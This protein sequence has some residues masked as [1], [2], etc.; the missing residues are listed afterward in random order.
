MFHYFIFYLGFCLLPHDHHAA[1]SSLS[2]SQNLSTLFVVIE[3]LKN[4]VLAEH[5]IHPSFVGKSI[6][7]IG[8]KGRIFLSVKIPFNQVCKVFGDDVEE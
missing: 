1:L 5:S 8:K 3:V 7:T 2:I 6:D 4:S